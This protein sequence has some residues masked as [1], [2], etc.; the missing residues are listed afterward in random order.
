MSVYQKTRSIPKPHKS[1]GITH[2]QP[3]HFC[4]K[5]E[6]GEEEEFKKKLSKK[7]TGGA[8]SSNYFLSGTGLCQSLRFCKRGEGGWDRANILNFKGYSY[9]SGSACKREREIDGGVG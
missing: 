5:Y 7:K 2:E 1:A 4:S 6:G 8:R 3:K 9:K